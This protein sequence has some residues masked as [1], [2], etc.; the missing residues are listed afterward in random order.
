MPLIYGTLTSMAKKKIDIEDKSEEAEAS[1]APSA[2]EIVSEEA[3]TAAK[4]SEPETVQPAEE[5]V[6]VEQSQQVEDVPSELT[7]HKPALSLPKYPKTIRRNQLIVI[8]V[9]LIAIFGGL[10]LLLTPNNPLPKKDTQL[11]KFKVYYPKSNSSGYAYAAGSASFTAG[12]LTYSLTPKNTHV[13]AGGP[14]IRITEQALS[15]SGPNLNA[16]TDFTIMKEPAG[17][18]AVGNNGTI[19]NGVIVTKKTLIILNGIDGAS[20]QD[21]LQIMKSM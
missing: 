19:V 10:Y 8:V 2:E 17:N 20:K 5:P 1:A 7:Q 12:Q 14:V 11:A 21:L 9:L 4:Q 16:L 18:A 3:N 13:G 15:G 6:S